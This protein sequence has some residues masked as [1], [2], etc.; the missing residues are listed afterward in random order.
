MPP[1][2][3]EFR[4]FRNRYIR[5]HRAN[6]THHLV[7]HLAIRKSL[8]SDRKITLFQNGIIFGISRSNF[9]WP[10]RDIRSPTVTVTKTIPDP[11]KNFG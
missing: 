1:W 2:K 10:R 8:D 6:D 7:L 4:R 3:E 11:G 9:E 5:K